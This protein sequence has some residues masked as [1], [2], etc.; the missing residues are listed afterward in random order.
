MNE[1]TSSRLAN[2][3]PIWGEGEWN[4]EP[5]RVQ[6]VDDFTGYDCLIKRNHSGVFCGYVAIPISHPMYGKFY[7]DVEVAV[8]GGLTYSDECDGYPDTGI[9]HVSKDDD[10]AWWLGF[11]CAHAGDLM[12]ATI[13]LMKD[14]PSFS[15]FGSSER[16]D[17][18]RNLDYA[19]EQVVILAVQLK[20][21][22]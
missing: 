21:M 16:P 17:V 2:K 14:F 4:D 10:K 7:D 11:D 6:W 5:D 22:E 18:Y 12:P 8:H 13:E 20:A 1:I 9:C 15:T 3:R 19:K